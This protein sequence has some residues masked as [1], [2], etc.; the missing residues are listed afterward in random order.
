M[1]DG[2]Y[3]VVFSGH[4]LDG[5]EASE[6]KAAFAKRFKMEPAQVENLFLGRHITLKKN[7]DKDN[8][9]RYFNALRAIGMG[10]AV[11]SPPAKSIEF[12]PAPAT[13][14]Q[15]PEQ[16]SAPEQAL[17]FAGAE[18]I[19]P[20]EPGLA[21]QPKLAPAPK[22]PPKEE[23]AQAAVDPYLP[24]TAAVIDTTQSGGEDWHPARRVPI[25]RGIG[26]LGDAWRL[27]KDSPFTWI[28][29]FVFFHRRLFPHGAHPYLG[30][31]R[32]VPALPRIARRHHHNGGQPIPW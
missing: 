1:A 7:L 29:N 26:W 30:C 28:V 23:R 21:A 14:T 19:Y 15:L 24:P 4:I 16:A 32:R 31:Y 10:V 2:T 20:A 9:E 6:V 3:S 13:E 5:F 18:K 11:A 12:E 27:F 8:A 22:R 17:V 25:G